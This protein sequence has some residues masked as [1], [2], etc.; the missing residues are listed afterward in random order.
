MQQD[1]EYDIFISYR[2]RNPIMDWVRLHF[3]PLLQERLSGCLPDDPKIFVDWEIE[4]GSAWPQKLSSALKRS[5][6][7]VA[8]WSPEYF[9]SVW[10]L[11]EWQSMQ[12]RE[13]ILGL[14]SEDN[15]SGLVYAIRFCDGE[16]FPEEA[17]RTQYRD[18]ERWNTKF[19]C[20]SETTAVLEFER[21]MKKVSEE[22]ARI[23]MR[24]PQW[25]EWPT[26]LPDNISTVKPR[27]PR[28]R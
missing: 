23:L 9:R 19:A 5:R 1:Y 22:I 10:C 8:I 21:E 20:F 13:K 25:Q 11:A 27:L 18:L 26:I 2:R 6:C 3:F 28:L 7:L 16:Y 12:E 17:Q 24:C 15:S 14:K 4:T